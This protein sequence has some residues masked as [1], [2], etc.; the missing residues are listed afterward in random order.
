M[1]E[2]GLA[3]KSTKHLPYGDAVSETRL[4]PSSLAASGCQI[5][6]LNTASCFV[7]IRAFHLASARNVHG[8]G[9]REWLSSSSVIPRLPSTA[10][11]K[12]GCACALLAA[13]RARD[14]LLVLQPRG[15]RI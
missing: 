15:Q 11:G 7:C 9:E 13:G 4:A 2:G 3:W 1:L 12:W 5:L 14:L 6:V 10:E 8:G